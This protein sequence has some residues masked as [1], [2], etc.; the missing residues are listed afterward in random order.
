MVALTACFATTL[1]TSQHVV[2]A[3]HETKGGTGD[4]NSLKLFLVKER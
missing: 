3:D 1:V 2:D 4:M